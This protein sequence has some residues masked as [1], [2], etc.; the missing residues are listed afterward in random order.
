MFV[1]AGESEQ[2]DFARPIGIG[3]TD[4]T[5]T[6]TKLCMTEKPE[7]IHFV[8]SAGSYGRYGIFD[9]VVSDSASN[10]ENSFFNAGAYSPIE[11]IVSCETIEDGIMVNSS[12]YITTD[13]TLGKRYEEQ[14]IYLENMEFY[15][16]LKVARAFGIPAKGTFVVTN[17][18]NANAHEDFLKNHQ[19]AMK[20]LNDYLIIKGK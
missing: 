10:I 12:N 15:A 13:S 17:Y 4:V 18:C 16:V 6:L 20:I 5:I 19:E 11:N 7:Q 14:N 3:L 1:C 2:F 8:G 9:I